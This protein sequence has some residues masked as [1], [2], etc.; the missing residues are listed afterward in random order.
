MSAVTAPS[1]DPCTIYKQLKIDTERADR[2]S[3]KI[4]EQKL[5]LTKLAASWM[6]DGSIS[7]PEGEEIV[8][9]AETADFRMW[10][11]L[12]YVISRDKVA[13]RIQ[14]VPIAKRASLGMEYIIPDLKRDEFDIVE[15]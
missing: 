3:A 15:V 14:E 2:H 6:A 11:P 1:S 7:S 10:R 12:L 9:M 4:T 13:N 8:Y 5:S